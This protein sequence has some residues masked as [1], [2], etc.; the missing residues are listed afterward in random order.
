MKH[1]NRQPKR[2]KK[3]LII[4]ALIA[5]LVGSSIGY[6]AWR[7]S[8]NTDDKKT[9]TKT[10]D[11]GINYEPP[12]DEEKQAGEDQKDAGAK[13][14][15]TTQQP[16]QT[17]KK[18]VSVVIADAG[19]YGDVIEV[20]AFVPEHIQDGTCTITIT[21][22]AAKVVKTAKAYADASSS[23]CTNPEILRSEFPTS[24]EWS[25]TVAYDSAGGRGES[26]VKKIT[27]Q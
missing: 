2:N 19:Q 9:T 8:N 11:S 12:T 27:I 5:V 24:G 26:A 13:D 25:V 22:D 15:D 16:P 7:A 17:E 1:T 14:P 10:D 20:R 3:I 4:A 21:K 18:Q 6:A 23:I